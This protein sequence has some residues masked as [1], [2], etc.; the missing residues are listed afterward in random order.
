MENIWRIICTKK[1]MTC[2]IILLGIVESYENISYVLV[3]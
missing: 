2:K 1:N 3:I